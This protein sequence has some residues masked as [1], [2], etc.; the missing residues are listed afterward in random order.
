MRILVTGG[1]GFVGSHI[2][3][4]LVKLGHDVVIYD[5]LCSQVH[6]DVDT[7]PTYLN[8]DA[9]FIKAD[10]R[11]KDKLSQALKGIDV[12]FHE[13]AV[14][15]VG[16]SMYEIHRY[17]ENNVL[18]TANLLDIIVNGK[19]KI[20]KLIVASSMSIYGEG[21]YQCKK[22]SVV[23]PSLRSLEQLQSR[24]WEQVCPK[25]A[26]TVNPIPTNEEK[27]IFPTSIYSITKRDQEDSCLTVC[28]AYRIPCVALRY[29]NI[30]GPRQSI[31]N[32]YTGVLA[33]FMSRLK[34]NNP[35]VV[36]EDGLQTRDFIHVS[37]IVKANLLSL[38]EEADYEMFNVGT[39][40]ANNLLEIISFFSETLNI[41][42]DPQPTKKY[43][44]G[45]IRHCFADISKIQAKLGF[46]PSMGLK[47]GIKDL[48]GWAQNQSADDQVSR[49]MGELDKKGLII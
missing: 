2:V 32:P 25:C 14:V 37:D 11:D 18:G 38:K 31:S 8:P 35:L 5:N 30:Y 45:D 44:Q 46:S 13:A 1:A 21:A 27:P 42:I 39:G 6:G 7:P 28:R 47:E 4:S 23:Y 16:Q 19:N 26:M 49:A 24:H 36:F 9:E 40:K 34:N 17:A 29:F 22:C 48:C 12:V 43:R 15:G 10:M 33:I 20:R 3:D 41:K